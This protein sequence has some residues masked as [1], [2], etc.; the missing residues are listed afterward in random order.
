[1]ACDLSMNLLGAQK[2]IKNI[3]MILI[4]EK[5]IFRNKER[6]QH[7]QM[8][9]ALLLLN[10]FNHFSNLQNPPQKHQSPIFYFSIQLKVILNCYE[11][12]LFKI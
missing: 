11:N 5:V 7:P 6:L 3:F 4:I 1:M 2:F 8:G 9:F 10:F 12:R